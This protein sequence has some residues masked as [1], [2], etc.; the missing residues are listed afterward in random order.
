MTAVAVFVKTPGI[1][2]VKTRLA[3]SL[4]RE[5]AEALYRRCAGAVAEIATASDIG[6]CHWAVAESSSLAGEAWGDLPLLE[7]GGG[8]LGERMSRVLSLLVERH[9][10]GLL[11]GADA[12]QIE[13]QSLERA[14]D[15]LALP[16]PRLVVGPAR[17]GG[18]WLVGANCGIPEPRW[19]GV[20]YSRSDTLECFRQAL[21]D[22]GQ[23]L[24]LNELTDLDTAA[25]VF[26]VREEL[27]GLRRPS[28]AQT[29][30]LETLDSWTQAGLPNPG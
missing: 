1:S 20:P 5:K 21:A 15:W 24:T 27:H 17:D 29:G 30:L 8:G 18:F 3:R 12:P 25:D 10:S 11:L 6:P 2:P 7:Q 23:W 4:G 13:V 28:A 9:G 22:C 19:T 26:R 16:A 14:R